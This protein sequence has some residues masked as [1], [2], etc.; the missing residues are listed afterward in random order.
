ML[1]QRS[2]Y[3]KSVKKMILW[4]AAVM[5]FSCSS[6]DGGAEPDPSDGTGGMT[7]METEAAGEL[8]GAF[9]DAAHPTSGNA[10]VSSNRKNL[11]LTDFKSDSGPILE[12]YI[13]SDLEATDYVTLGELQGLEGDFT[14]PIPEGV[15]FETHPYLIVWCVEF[16]VNFGYAELR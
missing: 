2:P 15:N 3:R 4:I 16:R 8:M 5:L 13:A 14:Y 12:L 7:G 6:P 9:M 1:I 10:T 11:M